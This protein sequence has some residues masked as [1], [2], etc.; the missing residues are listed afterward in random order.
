M[1]HRGNVVAVYCRFPGSIVVASIEKVVSIPVNFAHPLRDDF[2]GPMLEMA[3]GG[4][5]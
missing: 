4:F 3:L 1:S 5:P 2:C